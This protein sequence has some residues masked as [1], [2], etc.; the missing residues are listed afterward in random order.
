MRK[1]HAGAT[2][3]ENKVVRPGL[4]ITSHHRLVLLFSV[5]A[6]LLLGTALIGFLLGRGSDVQGAAS[7]V[8]PITGLADTLLEHEN[9]CAQV[10]Q[11]NLQQELLQAR[12]EAEQL[13]DSLIEKQEALQE[14]QE[15]L[16]E[17][18]DEM[19]RMEEKIL[20]ALMGNLTEKTI[21]RSSPTV[22]SYVQQA[23][24]L[25]LLQRK[26]DK[27]NDTPE[28]AEVDLTQY[29]ENIQQKLANIPTLK[30]IPGSLTGYGNRR[31]PI[32][33]YYHFHGAVDMGAPKGT[34]IKASAA[35]RVSDTGYNSSSGNFV[36]ISHGNGFETL[37]FHCSKVH[38]TTGERVSKG[39]VIADVGNT[40]TST[41]SHLHFGISFYGTPINPNQIIME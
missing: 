7:T 26:L 10:E 4:T 40:G 16:Q 3:Y 17:Q 5:V 20:N 15:A 6:L 32:Y 14:Q 2:G 13:A 30:P 28:A 1:K 18:Q 9:R 39:Q 29:E 23:Q 33:G 8:Q 37:Y 35:G 21:S 41:T 11:V 25:L 19:A 12:Q 36:K 38:V 34:P 24:D 22:A 31:H 27:F